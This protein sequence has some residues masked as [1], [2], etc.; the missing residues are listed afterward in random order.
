MKSIAITNVKN[1]R[2]ILDTFSQLDDIRWSMAANY[3]LINYCHDKLTDDEK[4]LTHWLCYVTD[5][6]MPFQRI[7]DIGGYAISHLVHAFT[8]EDCK[9][10]RVLLKSY[11]RMENGKIWFECPLESGNSRLARY[12]IIGNK[13]K[14]ASRYMPDDL[15]RIYRTLEILAF[16][17]KKSFA[18]F[19]AQV[20]TSNFKDDASQTV[21][22]LATALNELTYKV[23]KV[24]VNQ[25][26][27]ALDKMAEEAANFKMPN[28][29][30]P[31]LFGR[32]R[33]W[34][35]LR[36]YL[37]S[38]EF[39]QVFVA[40]LKNIGLDNSERW[41]RTNPELKRALAVIELPGN[42]WNNSEVFRDGLFSPCLSN[43]RQSWDMPRIIRIVYEILRKD[44]DLRFYPEQ[45]DVT[46]DFVP[47]MCQRNMCDVCL[48]GNGIEQV[49]HKKPGYLS[50]Y[51]SFLADINKFAILKNAH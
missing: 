24:A 43:E 15:V 42:V 29:L 28:K 21:R 5:R 12:E 4:L 41:S 7:W 49:C 34:C 33:L 10:V 27:Q 3:N 20:L 19:I 17:N 46:F 13:V 44:F 37:K 14:F 39:N 47:R 38:P 31:N 16:H 9:N 36:D 51:L 8:T 18:S 1:I 26:D 25:F 22:Y 32:K 2:T 40:S 50:P 45:L 30:K 23:G 48:F 35:S 11:I 6:Q